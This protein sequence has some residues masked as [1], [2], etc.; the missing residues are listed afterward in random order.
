MTS[1]SG[2]ICVYNE[3]RPDDTIRLMAKGSSDLVIGA[4]CTDQLHILDRTMTMVQIKH[5]LRWFPYIPSG[6]AI[7]NAMVAA[8]R[9]SD[10]YNVSTLSG[11]MLWFEPKHAPMHA[12]KNS[13]TW[14]RDLRTCFCYICMHGRVCGFRSPECMWSSEFLK[15]WCPQFTITDPCYKSGCHAM[16]SRLFPCSRDKHTRKSCIQQTWRASTDSL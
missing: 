8:I 11:I 14:V 15:L 3:H 1:E 4:R 6:R 2:W 5:K 9:S 10:L 12:Y 16:Q 7:C 13:C